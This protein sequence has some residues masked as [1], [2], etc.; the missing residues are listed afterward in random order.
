MPAPSDSAVFVEDTPAFDAY[1]VSY[2]GWQ[3]T[4]KFTSHAA[5]LSQALQEKG[6]SVR[7]DAYYAVGYDSPFR[8]LHRHNEVRLSPLFCALPRAVRTCGHRQS[9]LDASF[10]SRCL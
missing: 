2:G 7:G 6:V 4:A 5:E 10:R 9:L 3:T 8:L 1:V